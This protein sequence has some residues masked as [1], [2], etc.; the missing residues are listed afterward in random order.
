MLY[1]LCLLLCPNL[2]KTWFWFWGQRGEDMQEMAQ[3]GIKLG[4]LW[5]GPSLPGNRWATT[6][7]QQRTFT[8]FKMC[9]I[10]SILAD[11]HFDSLQDSFV[12]VSLFPQS[13][14]VIVPFCLN[15]WA[16]S[17]VVIP[18]W[19]FG[20]GLPCQSPGTGMV[21]PLWGHPLKIK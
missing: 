8:P 21:I 7:P 6:A 15:L 19:T 1:F 11:K 16:K 17:P 3:A 12:L 2:P 13:A 10:N 18:Q 5:L 9:Q 14:V 20:G 4:P